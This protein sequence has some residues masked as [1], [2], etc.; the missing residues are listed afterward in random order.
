MSIKQMHATIML[1]RTVTLINKL[2]LHARAASR[3]V[4]TAQAFSADI[5]LAQGTSLA[6]GKSIMAL[7]VLAAPCDTTLELTVDGEDE[8]EAM[9][10]LVSLIEDRFGE[11]E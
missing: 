7:L 3:L 11:G 5:T 6:N 8:V 4:E 10:A 9:D 1:Q 2:G